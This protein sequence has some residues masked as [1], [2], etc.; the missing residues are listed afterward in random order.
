VI[1]VARAAQECSTNLDGW[2][3]VAIVVVVSSALVLLH[4]VAAWVEKLADQWEA[5]AVYGPR[6]PPLSAPP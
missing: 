1:A 4:A 2:Q 5:T 3:A 6:S